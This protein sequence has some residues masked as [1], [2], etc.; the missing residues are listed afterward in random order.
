MRRDLRR[1]AGAD[2]SGAWATAVAA[3]REGRGAGVD[4]SAVSALAVVAAAGAEACGASGRSLPLVRL[5]LLRF[6]RACLDAAFRDLLGI[7]LPAFCLA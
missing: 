2:V 6:S 1:L 7:S 3:A 4:T 5:F